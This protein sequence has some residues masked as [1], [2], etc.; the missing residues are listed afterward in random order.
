MLRVQVIGLQVFGYPFIIGGKECL[1]TC[2]CCIDFEKG[3]HGGGSTGDIAG[4][5]IGMKF[6][7]AGKTHIAFV[8]YGIYLLQHILNEHDN[9]YGNGGE[10][11]EISA[12]AS[13]RLQRLLVAF[14]VKEHIVNNL[15]H[16]VGIASKL[17]ASLREVSEFMGQNTFEFTDVKGVYQAKADLQVFTYGQEHAPESGV[18][19]NAGINFLGEVDLLRKRCA[20]FGSDLLNKFKQIRLLITG[21]FHQSGPV[22]LVGSK[23]EF[24]QKINHHQSGADHAHPDHQRDEPGVIDHQHNPAVAKQEGQA[25]SRCHQEQVNDHKNDDG[26]HRLHYFNLKSRRRFD[27]SGI[28][29]GRHGWIG[30]L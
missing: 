2:L 18:V 30:D 7:L 21:D 5:G 20:G 22:C 15:V 28:S 29:A 12:D 13:P 8:D 26:S 14:V 24:Q 1:K 23:Y 25:D 9:A 17:H 4:D 3:M 19:K 10:E 11:R 6:H 16:I 27:D